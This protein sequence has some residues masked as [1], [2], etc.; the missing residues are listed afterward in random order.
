MLI[1]ILC[2]C[3]ACIP[4]IARSCQDVDQYCSECGKKL[5]HKPYDGATQVVAVGPADMAPSKY[6]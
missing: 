4:C 5:T 3:A 1:G 6:A 2:I